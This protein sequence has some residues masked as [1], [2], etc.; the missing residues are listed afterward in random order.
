MV[1]LV[2][3]IISFTVILGIINSITVFYYNNIIEIQNTVGETAEY[4][5][6]NL[7]MLKMV[8]SGYEVD[9]INDTEKYIKFS[10]YENKN[11]F[12]LKNNILYY[13]RIKLCKGIEEIKF[14]EKTLENGKKVLETYIKINDFEYTN[15]YVFS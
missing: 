11:K 13:N 5:K 4:N 2:L 3:Y 6:F 8:K 1:S 12:T 15:E 7:Y 9:E 14:K 10:K